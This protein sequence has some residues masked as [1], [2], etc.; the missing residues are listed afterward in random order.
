M[1]GVILALVALQLGW[2]S[3][4][5]TDRSIFVLGVGAL[6][7]LV[8]LA[9]AFLVGVVVWLALTRRSGDHSESGGD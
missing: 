6:G 2:T 8:N 4:A 9:V 7:L 5:E 1:L 3:F